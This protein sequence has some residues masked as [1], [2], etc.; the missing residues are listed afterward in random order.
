[1]GSGKS[2]IGP[3]LANTIGYDFIDIDRAIEKFVGKTINQIFR[4]DG[5]ERF[6][7]LERKLVTDVVGRKNVVVALGGGTIADPVSFRT[8]STSGIVVYLK[9]PP[10]QIL[11]R[12]RTRTDRPL[13]VGSTGE[14]LDEEALRAKA[15]N[16][17]LAREP[18]YERADVTVL[19]GERSVG[20]TVDEI[21]RKVSD[22]E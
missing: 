8:V 13:L 17:F 4:E 12:L 5:E 7:V 15:M 14:Q 11:A 2:T 10:Q 18:Y 20:L 16:L 3:I 21:V 19:A 22:V 6:R 9:I 1:M